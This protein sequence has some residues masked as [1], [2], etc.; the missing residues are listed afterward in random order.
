MTASSSR[1]R[2]GL[3]LLA[4]T[5]LLDLTTLFALSDPDS[6]KPVVIANCLAG[7]VTLIG[8]AYAWRGRR[9]GMFVVL[10]ALVVDLL[11]DVPV[12]FLEAPGWVVAV[13]TATLTLIVIGVVLVAPTL[14]RPRANLAG[15]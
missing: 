1:V 3:A 2:T 13:A 7:L 15:S 5:G 9:G 4:V 11:L 12:Y 10:A 8:V 14:R 6:P